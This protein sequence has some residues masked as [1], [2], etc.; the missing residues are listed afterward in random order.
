MQQPVV[1]ASQVED[2]VYRDLT[3]YV[4]RILTSGHCCVFPDTPHS[5]FSFLYLFFV[6]YKQIKQTKKKYIYIYIYI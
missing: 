2:D 6:H 4:S 3:S 5:S 1:N